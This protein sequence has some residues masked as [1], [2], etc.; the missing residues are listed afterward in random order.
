MPKS[1]KGGWEK[2]NFIKYITEHATNELKVCDVGAVIQSE[3]FW[4]NI[5]IKRKKNIC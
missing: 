2:D 1:Y 4:K 3:A 5:L